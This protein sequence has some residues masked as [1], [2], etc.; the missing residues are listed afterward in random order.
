VRG[1]REESLR[2]FTTIMREDRDI[3]EFVA[4]DWTWLNEEL[5]ALY[6]E[7]QV[8]GNYFRRVKLSDP[9]RGGVITMPATLAITSLPTRTS[10]VKRGKWILDEILGAP[11]PPPPPNV[12][13][14]DVPSGER[15]S[16]A[17][18]R[19]RLARHRNDPR[20]F[21]CHVQMDVLGLG[22]ENFDAL[23]RWRKQDAGQ[24]IDP[25]GTLPGGEKFDSPADL[26]RLLATREADFAR[27]LT[28]KMFVY[29]LGRKLT[30]DD[31]REVKR[32][33]QALE[34]DDGRFSTLITEI[35]RSYPFRYR[36][37]APPADTSP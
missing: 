15:S 7:R 36:E 19:E 33:V 18:L 3:G 16:A 37:A 12:P 11:P 28:E 29:A 23:G 20:C 13:D 30:P 34:R 24:A 8:K 9:N 27:C 17:T 1:T 5:A 35:V 4:A 21:G 32:V 6:G 25:A 31:R 2:F 22:L 26:K 14:L 10:A